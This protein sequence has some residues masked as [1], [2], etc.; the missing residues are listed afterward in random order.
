MPL[1]FS[2]APYN[3]F[4]SK[5][6]INAAIFRNISGKKYLFGKAANLVA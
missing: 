1:Q 6:P 4:E 3:Y 5:V 2:I